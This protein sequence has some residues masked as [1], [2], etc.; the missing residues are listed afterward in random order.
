MIPIPVCRCAN[1]NS[2]LIDFDVV[3][4]VVLH[5]FMSVWYGPVEC[6]FILCQ[7]RDCVKDV[8][9]FEQVTRW[10]DLSGAIGGVTSS[11]EKRH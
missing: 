9:R 1:R 11:P 7:F 5:R 10:S 3:V 6:A 4:Q 2:V 8:G